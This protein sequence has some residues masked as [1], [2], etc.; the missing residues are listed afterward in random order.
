MT[1]TT[2]VDQYAASVKLTQTQYDF[3][4]RCLRAEGRSTAPYYSVRSMSKADVSMARRLHDRG[5]LSCLYGE[6]TAYMTT[7]VARRSVSE[8][9]KAQ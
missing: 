1:S 9:E 7:P 8:F 6:H 2:P 3:L 5:L 4:K